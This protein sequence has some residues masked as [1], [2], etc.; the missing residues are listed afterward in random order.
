MP[1]TDPA[2]RASLVRFDRGDLTF[3]VACALLAAVSVA[4]TVRF[5]DE[6]SPEASLELKVGREEAG[7]IATAWIAEHGLGSP[8]DTG[9]IHSA[10]F[11]SDDE[12]RVFLERS[13][14]RERANE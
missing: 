11:W 5:H 10:G 4:L 12:A 8:S 9:R 3:F 2:A 14:G 13:L 7:D 6:A 1:E